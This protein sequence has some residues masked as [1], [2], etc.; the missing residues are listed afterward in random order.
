MTPYEQL[1]EDL[2]AEQAA[3]DAVLGGMTDA[4]WDLPSHAPGW[5]VRDQVA[6]LAHFDEAAASAITDAAAFRADAVAA[7][8]GVD[9]GTYEARVTRPGPRDETLG[10]AG[11][12]AR[13]R[14]D[15]PR[16]RAYDRAERRACPGMGRRWP[17]RSLSSRRG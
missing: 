1:L 6:H 9:R 2:V 4:Q 13:R 8:A 3:L 12:V 15:P 5:L 11:L 17:A 14:R 10:A 16:R 7:R